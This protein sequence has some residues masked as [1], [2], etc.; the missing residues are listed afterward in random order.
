VKVEN[1]AFNLY[2]GILS[3]HS[4]MFESIKSN[5]VLLKGSVE[6]EG[7]EILCRFLFPKYVPVLFYAH[8]TT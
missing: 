5:A 8:S 1:K 7:F 3:R 4:E 6:T 2:R